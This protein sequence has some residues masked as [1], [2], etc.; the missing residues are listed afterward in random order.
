VHNI[1]EGVDA[2]ERIGAIDRRECRAHFELN[3]SDDRMASNYL[4]I[5]QRLVH[6]KSA[7]MTVEEGVLNWMEVESQT[8]S[9]T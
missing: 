2:V 3:F 9:T 4:K 1:E 6:P 5:Y 8:P 7:S